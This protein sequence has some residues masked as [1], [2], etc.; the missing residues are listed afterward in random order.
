[1]MTFRE[2]IREAK[3]F[4]WNKNPSIGWWMDNSVLT[5][6]HG[7]HVNN[8]PHI[9]KNGLKA[10]DS[11]PTKDWVSMAF[12]PYTAHAYAAMGG[13]SGFRAAGAKAVSIPE[14]DRAVLVIR[15]PLKYVLQNI[16][17]TFSGNMERTERL[18]N[19]SRFD[20]FTGPDYSY[21]ML[22]EL[23]FPKFVQ[24][25]FIIGYTKKV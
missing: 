18:K 22:T 24:P 20:S 7:T 5:L 23:R 13:E 25:K 15:M 8:V 4:Q 10:P 3:E 2:F 9:I 16:D 17:K 6:Y 21:Y 1:M 14:K 19:K 11:G 12:D